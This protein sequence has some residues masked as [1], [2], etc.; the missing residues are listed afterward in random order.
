[1]L[2]PCLTCRCPLSA[3][4]GW[5]NDQAEDLHFRCHVLNQL[6]SHGELPQERR[7]PVSVDRPVSTRYVWCGQNLT[8]HIQW[9]LVNPTNYAGGQS[10]NKGA[11]WLYLPK[12]SSSIHASDPQ[13][14]G[15]VPWP[16]A[17]VTPTFRICDNYTSG[18]G[19]RRFMLSGYFCLL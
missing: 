19:N 5:G 2:A 13:L 7:P 15:D 10:T 18:D 8:D 3:G 11:L 17:A 14:H 16:V 4:D 6:L 12:S 1:M 9:P